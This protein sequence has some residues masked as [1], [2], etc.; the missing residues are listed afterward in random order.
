MKKG[1]KTLASLQLAE[2]RL[3]RC[4]TYVLFVIL[5]IE[6]IIFLRR[7]L[8]M[9]VPK[10]ISKLTCRSNKDCVKKLNCSICVD[11]F[12]T[13]V[14]T[15]SSCS[16]SSFVLSTRQY[17][18]SWY[19]HDIHVFSVTCL[20][21]IAVINFD[22]VYHEGQPD[23]FLWDR[24]TRN[25]MKNILICERR[26]WVH[27]GI[28]ETVIDEPA[29]EEWVVPEEEVATT[30]PVGNS[31]LADFNATLNISI[32][33]EI[34]MDNSSSDS[35]ST[36]ISSQDR[37][38]RAS[39]FELE[40]H[41]KIISS[42]LFSSGKNETKLGSE[43]MVERT[44]PIRKCLGDWIKKFNITSI[45][46]IACGE[47]SWQSLIPGIEDISYKGVDTSFDILRRARKRNPKSMHFGIFDITRYIP[48]QADLLMMY[49]VMEVLP[50]NLGLKA[51]KNALL[52]GAQWLAV[53]SYPDTD[54]NS[55]VT[56]GGYYRHN[57]QLEPFS[58]Q[59]I[60]QTC[61]DR[62]SDVN[63]E[64]LLVGLRKKD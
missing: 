40:E 63:Y 32:S 64:F 51:I 61:V 22:L 10:P 36:D 49:D 5:V 62:T 28:R 7:A 43:L 27:S 3:K 59:E 46:D 2:M 16:A 39:D 17:F 47:A 52:S 30:A 9:R 1:Q 37:S 29:T 56:K 60:S 42:R 35:N 23:N 19:Q 54:F 34:S 4:F 48:P 21:N 13:D 41:F 8:Y 31:S 20:N 12:C 57:I 11:H 38:K 45:V 33:D 53:S 18:L 44:A 6:I 24:K 55:N 26:M 25:F 58:I 14:R 15:G 50:L